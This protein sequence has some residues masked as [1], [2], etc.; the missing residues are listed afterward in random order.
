MYEPQISFCFTCFVLWHSVLHEQTSCD[1]GSILHNASLLITE[2]NYWEVSAGTCYDQLSGLQL[3]FILFEDEFY[4]VSKWPAAG[5]GFKITKWPTVWYFSQIFKE[6]KGPIQFKL[7][8][9]DEQPPSDPEELYR[10]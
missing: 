3:I 7:S 2:K 9:V 8:Y 1:S 6:S 5:Q 10:T 4:A